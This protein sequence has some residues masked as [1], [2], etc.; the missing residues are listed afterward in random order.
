MNDS[1]IHM[2]AMDWLPFWYVFCAM[3]PLD[4][5]LIWI[6]FLS[7]MVVT[8]RSL[9]LPCYQLNCLYMQT[10]TAHSGTSAECTL[11]YMCTS[12][13]VTLVF[14]MPAVLSKGIVVCGTISLHHSVMS[15]IRDLSIGRRLPNIC[16]HRGGWHKQTKCFVWSWRLD[17][18]TGIGR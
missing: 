4:F 16:S 14:L 1:G 13:H 7:Q 17:S 5:Q 8:L 6:V 10:A 12:C 11:E 2:L 9:C 3:L 15:S 18:A